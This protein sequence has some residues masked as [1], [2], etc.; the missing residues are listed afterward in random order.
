MKKQSDIY[1][2]IRQI[3]KQIG[4][5][6]HPEKVI[7]FGSYATGISHRDSDVD[8]MVI[9]SDRRNFRKKYVE[10]SREIEPRL[11]P[12]DLLIRS[13]RQIKD[14]L[15]IGDSFIEEIVTQGKILYEA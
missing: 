5:K 3:A 7:L 15:K 2:Y 14:R 6:F 4:E 8:L 1:R 11:F 12:V 10:I 9:F 13:S